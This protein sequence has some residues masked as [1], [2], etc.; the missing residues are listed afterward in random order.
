VTS[1]TGGTGISVSASTGGVTISNTAAS[2]AQAF[3][4]FGTTA[5]Y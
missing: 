1:V 5:G 4:A 2:G 3:V